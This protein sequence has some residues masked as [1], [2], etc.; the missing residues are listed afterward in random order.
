MSTSEQP[1]S[2]TETNAE[3]KAEDLTA[4]TKSELT[5]EQLK[6]ISG[7]RFIATGHPQPTPN[8]TPTPTSGGTIETFY[9]G[10]HRP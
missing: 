6:E 8:P 3:A 10:A 5:E 1:R 9:G 4:P 7:G 2:E